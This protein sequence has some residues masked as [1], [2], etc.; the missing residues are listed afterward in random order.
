[1]CDVCRRPLTPEQQR[2]ADAYRAQQQALTRL[3]NIL[4][5]AC[6]PGKGRQLCARYGCN[7]RS[8]RGH[9]K[10]QGRCLFHFTS[11]VW[12]IE[13]AVYCAGIDLARK[14]RG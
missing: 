13:W 11:D 12:G 9:V 14:V 8:L 1:M 5:D 3:F 7:R 4:A 2:E 6:E 10:G